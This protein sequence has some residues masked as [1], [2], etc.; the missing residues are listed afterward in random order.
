MARADQTSNFMLTRALTRLARC[1]RAV[2][3]GAALGFLL[4]GCS[5]MP[6]VPRPVP[7][8][9][10]AANERATKAR[11]RSLERAIAGINAATV[12]EW[13][14]RYSAPKK[15]N[16]GAPVGPREVYI[17][18]DALARRHAAWQLADTLQRE[19]IAPTRA[20]QLNVPVPALKAPD[21]R[22]KSGNL[23]VPQVSALPV[24]PARAVSAQVS[25]RGAIVA[26]RATLD[27]FLSD[28]RARQNDLEVAESELARRALEDRI[29]ASTRGAVEA[30]PL[31][32]VA[33]ETALELSN[34]RL[35]LLEQLRGSRAQKAEATAKIEAIEKRLGEIWER[36]TQEQNARLRAAFEELP[37]RLRREGLQAL[38][39]AASKRESERYYARLELRSLIENRLGRAQPDASDSQ[40]LRLLLPSARVATTDLSA[41]G[42]SSSQT[43]ARH[44]ASA[45]ATTNDEIR[46]NGDQR[47][48]G[49]RASLSGQKVAQLRAQA[50]SDAR[51]WASKLALSWNAKLSDKPTASDRTAL[52]IAKLF[53][54][55]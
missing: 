25:Q 49:E 15:A 36:Q 34:L 10:I 39:A 44:N 31:A 21:A 28:L 45:L 47:P 32:P 50:R 46:S 19:A 5:V 20:R 13:V 33:P 55:R 16:A 43:K 18:V 42:D 23:D 12:R 6:P 38:D 54:A 35:Q 48:L 7:A 40:I 29:R 4:G 17:D 27:D 52:A 14:N 53:E 30:I 1:R 22:T 24:R 41:I 37:A 51:Q 8:T 9:E 3:P 26:S 2:W 11:S